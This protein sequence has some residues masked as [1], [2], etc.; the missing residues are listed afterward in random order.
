TGGN[1]NIFALVST[2][3]VLKLELQSGGESA[4][5]SGLERLTLDAA[6]SV[7]KAV[8]GAGWTTLITKQLR[9]I[10]AVVDELEL[11]SAAPLSRGGAFGVIED[12][13][14]AKSG[15]SS[16][17]RPNVEENESP[18]GGVP[19]KEVMAGSVGA[20]APAGWT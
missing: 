9:K 16:R 18:T 19:P 11:L 5:D 6:L 17:A 20:N 8:V 14:G 13:S 10:P 1:V 3:G 15:M 2:G 4:V 7:V 12:P